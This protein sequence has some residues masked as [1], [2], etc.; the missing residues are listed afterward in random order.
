MAGL[1]SHKANLSGLVDTKDSLYAA[2]VIH[3]AFFQTNDHELIFDYGDIFFYITYLNFL[4]NFFDD[5]KFFFSKDF[6]PIPKSNLPT[7]NANHPFVYHIW[8]KKNKIP[9]ISG[10]INEVKNVERLRSL[11]P[12]ICYSEP[13]KT[14]YPEPK[15]PFLWFLDFIWKSK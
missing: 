3:K 9:I 4:I 8:D 6:R 5:R 2:D 11:E 12:A 14:P 1:F 10:R 13:T 7:I 15:R